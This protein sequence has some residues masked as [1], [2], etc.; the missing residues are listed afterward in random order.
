MKK[1]Y[2]LIL[3][4]TAFTIAFI[5]PMSAEHQMVHIDDEEYLREAAYR[6]LSDRL[7]L[8]PQLY[9]QGWDTLPQ[10]LF[11][12]QVM[13]LPPDSSVANI[14]AT[15]KAL[16]NIA[17]EDYFGKAKKE[18][19]QFKDSLRNVYG[20]D[21]R[22][23]IYITS[24]KNH[25]YH[26]DEVLPSILLATDYFREEKVDPWYAQAILL[27]ESPNNRLQVSPVGAYGPFQLMKSVARA[28]GLVVNKEV[29]ERADLEKS[30]RGAASLISK[31][32]IPKARA[33]LDK[34]GIPYRL[35]DTWFRLMVL[36]VYHAGGRNVEG[37]IRKLKPKEG[38]M[39]LIRNLWQTE[40]RGFRNAS[41]NY[42][43]VALAT[44][45]TL[46]QIV[47]QKKVPERVLMR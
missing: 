15:R 43:Q 41:Q 17:S 36:H 10:S 23:E 46:H 2:P 4:V 33:I 3:A 29:D 44:M 24:G 45:L 31:V 14:A 6:R 18:R 42:S 5:L 35:E 27:I 22:E 28:H 47:E 21:E 1:A 32:C 11:W 13:L 12:Q 7:V 9:E 30:A 20:L 40:Y 39:G 26:F 34:H 37:A 38:G 16:I 8:D 19:K 25:F